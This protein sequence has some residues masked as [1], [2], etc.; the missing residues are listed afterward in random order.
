MKK[1]EGEKESVL[2]PVEEEQT[3]WSINTKER[4]LGVV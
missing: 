1:M 3:G 2:L 4:K